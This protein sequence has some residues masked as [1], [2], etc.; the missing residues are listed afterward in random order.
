MD[1]VELKELLIKEF[2]KELPAAKVQDWAALRELVLANMNEPLADKLI[3]EFCKKNPEPRAVLNPFGFN[4][5]EQSATETEESINYK[6]LVNN[7]GL[8]YRKKE[9]EKDIQALQELIEKV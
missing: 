6:I 9:I 8:A 1:A 4:G 7:A 2:S 5:T 3:A